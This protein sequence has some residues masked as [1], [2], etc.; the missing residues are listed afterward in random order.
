MVRIHILSDY[1]NQSVVVEIRVIQFKFR[2]NKLE[3]QGMGVKSELTRIFLLYSAQI[4]VKYALSW[5][6]SS[7]LHANFAPGELILMTCLGGDFPA[8]CNHES[9]DAIVRKDVPIRY[10]NRV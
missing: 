1:G 4:G 8:I 2:L 5:R 6:D 9:I 10:G 3:T 7:I